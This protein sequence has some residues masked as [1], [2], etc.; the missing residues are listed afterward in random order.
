MKKERTIYKLTKSST[1][2]QILSTLFFV[3]ETKQFKNIKK[4][5]QRDEKFL[6]N[7]LEENGKVFH[8]LDEDLRDNKKLVLAA[9]KDTPV[10]KGFGAH[11]IWEKISERLRNDRDVVYQA[12]MNNGKITWYASNEMISDRKFILRCA[13]GHS[14]ISRG[15]ILEELSE[16][17][18]DDR[19]IVLECVKGNGFMLKHATERLR[20]DK[21]IGLTAVK[22]HGHGFEYINNELKNDR[23]FVLKLLKKGND[24][25][26]YLNEEMR[27]DDEIAAYGCANNGS[28]LQ[29]A[30]DRLKK[31]KN[32][33]LI[34]MKSNPYAYSFLDKSLKK[35]KDI[36]KLNEKNLPLMMEKIK[37]CEINERNLQVH[38]YNGRLFIGDAYTM[39]NELKKESPLI[40][41]YLDKDASHTNPIEKLN[42]DKRYPFFSLGA[43]GGCWTPI[44]SSEREGHNTDAY[45]IDT[46]AAELGVSFPLSEANGSKEH[47]KLLNQM[48]EKSLKRDIELFE[49][50]IPSRR[51]LF[52]GAANKV[53]FE[54]K[55]DFK[56]DYK[57]TTEDIYTDLK[58]LCFD[59]P[60]KFINFGLPLEDY[61][62]DFYVDG[63]SDD[64]FYVFKVESLEKDIDWFANYY[65]KY[66]SDQKNLY[67]KENP[68]IEDV[69]KMKKWSEKV[70]SMLGMKQTLKEVKEKMSE[71]PI[72]SYKD[73]VKDHG[74]THGYYLVKL[75]D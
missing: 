43:Y 48:I 7:I 34:A 62:L 8:Y 36:L 31:D 16:E 49:F 11:D 4:E 32:L 21:E 30:S 20:L 33:A 37:L 66:Y 38:I 74:F 24:I 57:K 44:Y 14:D 51:V 73:Y 17:Y 2:R 69:K 3:E 72:L 40:N 5:L 1:K 26:E 53:P 18:G 60:C 59:P 71:P 12:V 63:V 9:L 28:G 52:M 58:K 64:T 68:N 29:Y 35:D 25:F 13:K 22:D 50:E 54:T 42:K 55:E 27:D 56:I 46:A 45:F 75:G 19:E 6:I 61:T 65:A 67:K 39:I 15:F 23:K 41:F 10:L 47:L 70:R